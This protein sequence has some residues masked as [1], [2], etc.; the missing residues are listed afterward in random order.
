MSAF[1]AQDVVLEVRSQRVLDVPGISRLSVEDPSVVDVRA[2]NAGQ[3]WLVGVA[4]GETTVGVWHTN[5]ELTT[6]KVR[7]DAPSPRAL[8][9]GGELLIEDDFDQIETTSLNVEVRIL[10][11]GVAVVRAKAAGKATVVLSLRGLSVRDI[12]IIVR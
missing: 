7:V 3:M 2:L 5:G 11:R 1:A 6:F 12:P 8:R 4:V 10:A 9:L